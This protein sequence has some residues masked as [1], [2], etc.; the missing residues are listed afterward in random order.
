[1]RLVYLTA[2]N[3]KAISLTFDVPIL[4]VTDPDLIDNIVTWK[5][6]PSLWKGLKRSPHTEAEKLNLSIQFKGRKLSDEIKK[7]MSVSRK[8]RKFSA[9][10]KRKIGQA[11]HL[12]ALKRHQ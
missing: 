2:E 5:Q 10:H 4:G 12:A 11:V 9:E 3:D 1:M 6:L 7:K 8:G